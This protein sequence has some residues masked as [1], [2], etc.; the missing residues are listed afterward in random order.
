M[1]DRYEKWLVQ[2]QLNLE[3]S[4]NQKTENVIKQQTEQFLQLSQTQLEQWRVNTDRDYKRHQIHLGHIV[5]PLEKSIEAIKKSH[6]SQQLH[7][8]KMIEAMKTHFVEQKDVLKSLN[9]QTIYLN[10]LFSNTSKQGMFGEIQLK[11]LVESAGMIE[12]TH[13]ETQKS[14]TS[15]NRPDMI[16]HLPDERCIIIDAKSPL[17]TFHDSQDD[18]SVFVSQIRKHIQALS[19][20]QYWKSCENT[21]SFVILFLPFDELLIKSIESDPLLVDYAAQRQIVLS[22]PSLLLATLKSVAYAW[23]Q[24]TF[25]EQSR[26][27]YTLANDLYERTLVLEKHLGDM[28]RSLDKTVQAFQK[29][30]ASW[31]SRILPIGKRLHKKSQK[32][33]KELS[34][35][36]EIKS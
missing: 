22:S 28:G 17:K 18:I 8:S 23:Q 36:P 26:E 11:K 6:D 16:V 5:E 14:I 29:T 10:Q 9:T 21:P 32:G 19:Q 1:D 30:S 2:A 4:L 33:K 12:H 20:K 24:H 27:I 7:W 34:S 3:K 31:Q 25:N 35:L 13:F 15:D